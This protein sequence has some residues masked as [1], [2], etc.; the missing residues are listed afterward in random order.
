M[1]V[2]V[3]ALD[4]LRTVASSP[5]PISLADVSASL[6]LPAPTVHRFLRV[7]ADQG[8][9]AKDEL[10]RRYTAGPQVVRLVKHQ[11]GAQIAKAAQPILEQLNQRFDETVFVNRLID[12]RVVCVAVIESSRPLRLNIQVGDVL[13]WHAA[14]SARSILAYLPDGSAERLIEEQGMERFTVN[15]PQTLEQVHWHLDYVRSR[16]YD[17]CDDELDSGV[18]AAAAP[19]LG[20]SG[21]LGSITLGAPGERLRGDQKRSDVVRSIREAADRIAAAVD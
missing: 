21:V 19:L 7:L 10:N 18:W 15:T 13:A 20:A 14:A 11:Q 6:Q 16:G 12:D 2:V 4:I 9:I 1:Q 5:T 3:R 8:F 17:V